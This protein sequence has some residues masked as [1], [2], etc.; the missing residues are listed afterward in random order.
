MV[1][2]YY[3]ILEISP[4]AQPEEIRRSF[5]RL[6]MEWHPDRK[7]ENT[8]FLDIREAYETLS[9]PVR[10]EAY[11]RSRSDEESLGR[12]FP[13]HERKT[14]S[15]LMGKALQLE[16]EVSS[17]DAFRIDREAL[18]NSIDECLDEASVDMLREETDAEYRTQLT[19][20]LLKCGRPLDEAGAKRLTD[21][22]GRFMDG[23]GEGRRRM[24]AYLLSKRNE[25][26][27]GRWSTPLLLVLT[28]LLCLLISLAGS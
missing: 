20:I 17:M 6:A 5:R 26:R 23:G 19:R 18:L 7:G 15:S 28:L 27:W 11:L 24:D 2:D 9:D 21:M 12:R 25:A 22:L 16:R 8:R 14:P 13:G 4:Q 10:K 3:R 1:K